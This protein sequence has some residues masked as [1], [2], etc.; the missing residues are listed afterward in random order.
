MPQTQMIFLLY[1][2][3]YV[4]INTINHRNTFSEKDY[5]PSF[6]MDTTC[7]D[8]PNPE[9]Y[10]EHVSGNTSETLSNTVHLHV[11]RISQHEQVGL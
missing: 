8:T 9:K 10:Q 4:S 1:C 11:R 7:S 3:Q 5:L 6:L 2:V